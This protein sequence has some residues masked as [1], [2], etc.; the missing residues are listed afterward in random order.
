MKETKKTRN[1]SATNFK[2]RHRTLALLLLI[3]IAFSS[4]SCS[5]ETESERKSSSSWKEFSLS[6]A[7]LAPIVP[8]QT[9]ELQYHE[10]LEIS[11]EKIM[12]IKAMYDQKIVPEYHTFPSGVQSIESGQLELQTYGRFGNSYAIYAKSPSRGVYW[13]FI[14]GFEF[15]Y[16]DVTPYIYFNQEF[17]ELGEAVEKGLI[18]KGDL[19]TIHK[20]YKERN[21][22]LYYKQYSYPTLQWTFYGKELYVT[23]QPQ[24]NDKE[25]TVEDFAEIGC[26]AVEEDK[27][28][29]EYYSSEI[30]PNEIYRRW[31][32][33]LGR[34][35]KEW[36][37]EVVA[38]LYEREDV[39]LV[40]V[41]SYN[42]YD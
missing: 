15:R 27:K 3:L 39:F 7:D 16:T 14:K 26:V 30:L 2:M 36:A 10:V 6:E 35:S 1:T 4:A 37:I 12:E 23:V 5:L 42:E 29:Y 13:E 41:D 31:R 8:A 38:K 18:Y 11:E 33:D 25:Y 21:Y 34:E 20:N 19:E 28:Y 17:Y 9:E 24:Y 40:N 22:N 32:L